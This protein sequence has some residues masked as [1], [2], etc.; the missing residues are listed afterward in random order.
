MAGAFAHRTAGATLQ[1]L[2]AAASPVLQSWKKHRQQETVDKETSS[3]IF[4]F[5][6]LDSYDSVGCDELRSRIV[7]V[8]CEEI[9][10][11]SPKI[12]TQ[13]EVVTGRRSFKVLT[14]GRAEPP[15]MEVD[16][17]CAAWWKERSLKDVHNCWIW[18]GWLDFVQACPF[19]ESDDTCRRQESKQ[20]FIASAGWKS[21]SPYK[22]FD[23]TPW[24]SSRM[25]AGLVACLS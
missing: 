25:A 24:T 4:F 14:T 3:E 13:L 9:L 18:S 6:V 7:L 8:G 2:R 16:Q 15:K 21:C 1:P 11:E 5:F 19:V 20:T 17:L 12:L 22:K 23:V 10:V